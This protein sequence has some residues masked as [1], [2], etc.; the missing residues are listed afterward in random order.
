MLG[1]LEKI[2]KVTRYIP[3]LGS[4]IA[5]VRA[6]RD[7]FKA[8]PEERKENELR[9]YRKQFAKGKNGMTWEK[10]VKLRTE[11]YPNG[12]FPEDDELLK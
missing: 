11:L 1:T 3:L 9:R 5:A 6:A 10:Y 4:I 7:E 2:E 12:D 8:T